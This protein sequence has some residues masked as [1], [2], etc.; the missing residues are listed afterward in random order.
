MLPG[1]SPASGVTT[2]AE[3][4]NFEL[5]GH[6][7]L[8]AR[9]MNAAIA[10]HGDHVYVGSRTDGTPPHLTPGVLVVDV[11]DPAQPTVVGEI[12]DAKQG[13]RMDTSREL[14]VWPEADLLLVM[15][16]TCSAIL[17]AC[18]S[19]AD[20]SGP[21]NNGINVYD[22]REPTDPVL[23]ASISHPVAPHEMFLWADP[24]ETD[25]ALLYMS[26]PRTGTLAFNMYVADL[27]AEGLR[28]GQVQPLEEWWSWQTPVGFSGQPGDKRLHSMG[29]SADGNRAYLA[30][31]GGGML[32]VD[33]SELAS[34]APGGQVRLVTPVENRVHWGDPGAHSAVKV[35]GRD[36]VLTT[37]EVYGDS[38]DVITGADHG[39]PWGWVRLVDVTDETRPAVV[40]EFRTEYNDPSYCST[41]EGIDPSNTLFTS[42]SAHNPTIAGDIAFVTW[43]SAGLRAISLSDPSNPTEL[44]RFV[45]EPLPVVGTEDPALSAGRNK[46]V[47]WSYPII[48]DGLIY[49]LDVRNGLYVLRYT[50]PG[51]SDVDGIGFLEGNSNLGDAAA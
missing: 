27:S 3:A 23:V 50:G 45:P 22:I 34:G 24:A 49:V 11:S 26:T 36:L 10:K 18:A 1:V 4:V 41:P 39:C 6:T 15:N 19:T 51:H 33:T 46:V 29:V 37:D 47:M 7:P 28:A 17:H 16:F 43:H 35:P 5:V 30:Y 40:S 14:R 48:S 25:R 13:R 2:P 32:V 21:R 38:L 8:G 42:Y 20:V 12:S 31:L 44:G 9:G